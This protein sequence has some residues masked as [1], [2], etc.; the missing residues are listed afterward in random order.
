MSLALLK[1]SFKPLAFYSCPDNAFK[2]NLVH[3]TT[4]SEYYMKFLLATL[5]VLATISP[6]FAQKEQ[7]MVFNENFEQ[8]FPKL[9]KTVKATLEEKGCKIERDKYS[10]GEDGLFKG[11]I[12]S[13][14]CVFAE[15]ADSTMDRLERYSQRV[16]VIR[17]GEWTAGRIQ[18]IIILKEKADNTVDM[19]LKAE[20]S[21][22]ENYVTH[23]VH[24]WPANGV[25]EQEFIATLK[26]NIAKAKAE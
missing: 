10:E 11:N 12:R 9:F 1:N 7:T 26:A 3:F 17:A 18:Y 21:G 13:E 23:Q 5:F 20:I 24:F 4:F 19:E 6:A 25:L 14:F 16:P 15:G 22:F 8:A 2:N